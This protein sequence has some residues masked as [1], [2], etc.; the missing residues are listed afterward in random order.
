[1]LYVWPGNPV[2]GLF[3]G[4]S[5]RP[6][7]LYE[8]VWTEFRVLMLYLFQIVYPITQQFSIVHAMEVPTSPVTPWTT[9]PAMLGVG[10]LLGA[11]IAYM[12]RFRLFAFAILFFF[13]GHSIES[14]IF[15][16]ELVFEHRNYLP[17]LFLF[18]PVASGMLAL[19]D[20]YRRRN[21]VLFVILAAFVPLL[22]IGLAFATYTRNMDWATEK[23]LWQDAIKKAPS[24]ARPYQALALAYE[25]EGQL[26][27]AYDLY[28]KALPL[29][30]PDPENS[31]FNSLGNMGNIL[32]KQ[33]DFDG[34][35][36]F[37]TAA[38]E[39]EKGPYANN[40]RYNLV[41]CLLNRGQVEDARGHIDVLLEKDHKNYRYLSINGFLL[42]LDN[43]VEGALH[44]LR[45]ALRRN[46]QDPNT[47]LSLAMALSATG[48]FEHGAW[49][50]KRAD[51]KLPLNIVIYLSRLQNAIKMQDEGRIRTT[52]SQ[53][54]L[55]FSIQEIQDFFDE[56]AKGYHVIEGTLVLVDDCIVHP[57][58]MNYFQH[59]A[60]EW[61]L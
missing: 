45:M 48:A 53:I 26:E 49:Y 23:T 4:Y 25:N 55:L 14:T 17:T 47:L 31:R 10:L 13:L 19:L 27:K 15:P 56:H 51:E 35:V 54:V 22:I 32:K 21:A 6:F 57:V 3:D 16:L 60:D 24:M 36:R 40:V 12:R 58:L 28:E 61:D 43:D 46:P 34:A 50:L 39:L 9:L 30:D 37:L 5:M 33:K 20:F 44:Y 41:L 59:K 11:A 52:L 7:T 29:D 8:R 18:L 38:M 1:I 42:F 2:A